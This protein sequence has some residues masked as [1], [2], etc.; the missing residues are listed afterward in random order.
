MVDLLGRRHLLSTLLGFIRPLSPCAQ[1]LASKVERR[2]FDVYM[3]LSVDNR[4]D[5]QKIKTELLKEFERGNQNREE[6]IYELN[7][8]QC[9]PVNQLTSTLTKA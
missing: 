7:S 4:K 8:R 6:A 2:A 5:E 9:K 3:R 1:N